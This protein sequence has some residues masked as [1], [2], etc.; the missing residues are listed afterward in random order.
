VAVA[1]AAP[2]ETSKARLI[3]VDK[4]GAPQT[5]LRVSLIGPDRKTPDF[6]PLQV[7]NAALGGLF[8]SR[9]NTV[10]REE[11]G[12]TYGVYSRF[13]YRRLAGPFSIAGS[14]RTDVTGPAV[15][16]IFTQV[17]GM[18]SRP[19]A[20]AELANAR[21]AQVL[22]LPG[23]FEANKSIVS[24]MANTYI[25]DLGTDYYAKLPARYAG[26]TA[27][28]VQSVAR[29]YLRPANMIVIAV[30]DRSKIEP[31][32]STLPLTPV[33]YRAADATRR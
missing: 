5:A 20:G 15:A 25:Y 19:L 4:P 1:P 21:N 14:F 22:S 26:V 33:E 16:G 31:Q 29:K 13:A 30:G 7:M 32:L 12:Y 23:Q 9:L 17:N 18:L 28:Q 6:A 2:V 11:K 8:T 3:V 27:A 10:L 24:S